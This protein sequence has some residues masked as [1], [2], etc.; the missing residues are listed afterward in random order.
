[1]GSPGVNVSVWDLLYI[2]LAVAGC[3]QD[4]V[5]VRSY[6]DEVTAPAGADGIPGS[7]G[8]V[9]ALMADIQYDLLAVACRTMLWCAPG[10][11]R[12]PL[13]LLLW[14]AQGLCFCVV[15]AIHMFGC[16]WLPAGPRCGAALA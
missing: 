12:S 11:M 7:F 2:C 13:L 8:M 5:V 1:V 15:H 10:L 9:P 16:C 3:L 14:G 4:H 6:P